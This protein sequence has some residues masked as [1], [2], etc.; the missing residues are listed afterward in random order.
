AYYNV[1]RTQALRRIASEAVR[2]ADD[3]LDVARKLAKGG[4]IEREKVLRAEVQL[5]ES[6]RLLDASNEAVGVALAALNLAI[7]IN[8]TAPIRVVEPAEV[9]PFTPTLDD[10]LRTAIGSRREFQVAR[11]SIGI[12]QEGKRVAHA[13]FAPR[14]VGEGALFDLQQQSPRGRA[15]IALGFI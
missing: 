5:A 14:I 1:L 7:G 9:P 8:S 6:Q 3:E 4:V 15:D 13:E 10:C 11:T 2:R 12:A